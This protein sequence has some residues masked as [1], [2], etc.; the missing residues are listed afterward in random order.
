MTFGVPRIITAALRGGA[1]KTLI[2][3]G[4][5]AALRRRGILVSAF[6]KGPDYIDAGWL[7][8][9]AGRECYNLDQYLFNNETLKYSFL[10]R[11]QGA[12]A[13]II[14]GNRGL[15]DG[16]DSNGSY[17]TAE[18]AKLLKSPV[19]LIIDATKMTRTA[20]ALVL[21]CSAMDSDL[22]L[23]G[24]ILNRV[25]GDR[26]ER[27]LRESIE[28]T[29]SVPVIG[30]VIKLS[31]A[32]FP[33]RHLGLLPLHEHP[34]AAEFVEEAGN[35]VERSV[36]LDGL[37][38]IAGSAD[39]FGS[40]PIDVS[41]REGDKNRSHKGI[42]VGIMKDS[43]FQFY[44]PEN[45]ESL[46]STG[47]QLV[48]VSA[49]EASELPDLD[50]LYIGGGFPEMYAERLA[51][52][53]GFRRSL[54]NAIDRDL[55]VYAE[56]GGLMYL[57]RS[58]RID[59]RV[60]PMVGVFQADTVL[61]RKPQGLGYVRVQVAQPNPFYPVGAILSGHEF[62][63]SSV[64]GLDQSGMGYAFE[65]LRGHGIDGRRDGMFVRNTL[66]T[67]MHVHS[68]GEPLWACGI[69]KKASE[70]RRLSS[71]KRIEGFRKESDQTLTGCKQKQHQNGI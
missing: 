46:T 62:H 65:V 2:T 61:E 50:C 17:S 27:I 7:G 60:F 34:A 6:K 14:E 39:Q 53:A 63:Y 11:S 67:Y 23:A 4:L 68:L 59:E 38:R 13:A 57:S 10:R 58:I 47:A 22:K 52:N 71:V 40:A 36:D 29:C 44:Y 19:I 15:F 35:I 51:D 37:M 64:S 3:V 9:A 8:L 28:N 69:L 16:V 41:N 70:F 66:G 43:A 26:H 12:H 21:G 5:I 49:L 55:P 24:V 45:L 31:L 54:L 56:C 1:G 30:S 33:Q 32:N 20:V 48:P 18:L 42:R 25:A